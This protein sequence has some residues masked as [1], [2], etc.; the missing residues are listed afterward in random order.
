MTQLALIPPLPHLDLG[1]TKMHLLLAHLCEKDE[2]I[3]FYRNRSLHG[4]YLILDNSAFEFGSSQTAMA[5]MLA[6]A[7]Y[8]QVDEIVV[9]DVIMHE[10]STYA[11]MLESA[12]FMESMVG[13]RAWK[14][15]G[16]PRI[17]V[18]PQVHPGTQEIDSYDRHARL[19]MQL[20]H[21]SIPYLGGHIT[22]GVSKNMNKLHGGW[23]MLFREVVQELRKEYPIQVHALGLP[24]QLSAIR[25][26]LKENPY[27]RSID[28][29]L[30]FVAAL[31]DTTLQVPDDQLPHR[32]GDYLDAEL[33]DGQIDLAKQNV[34]WM[35]D[36]FVRPGESVF[37]RPM[38]NQE[39]V[40]FEAS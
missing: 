20:W 28:T 40:K 31:H 2:Y 19:L 7:Y 29:A 37:Q 11:R 36:Y 13:Q 18:V 39:R 24:K 4:D 33:T 38:T 8:I 30:P 5:D 1:T 26:T 34:D 22:L 16:S 3:Q 6:L 21:S 10:R 17:M 23:L 25:R 9:P 35:I 12:A 14:R 15:A 27:I 32:P